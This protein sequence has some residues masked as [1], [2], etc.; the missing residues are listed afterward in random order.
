MVTRLFLQL[1]R[2]RMQREIISF[3]Q[4]PSYFS[5]FERRCGNTSTLGCYGL[6][7]DAAQIYRLGTHAKLSTAVVFDEHRATRCI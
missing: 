1:F 6:V 3:N 5:N 4:S 2:R 7:S